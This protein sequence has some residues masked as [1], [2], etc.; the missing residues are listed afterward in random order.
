[1]KLV[2]IESP[3]A[4]DVET[5]VAYAKACVVD[6]LKRGESPY[7]SHLFFTQPGLLDDRL[8][9]ERTAGIH[10]GFAWGAKADLVAVYVD[11]G[12]SGGMKQGVERA[13]AAGQRIEYR[14]LD[15]NLVAAFGAASSEP[16]R[17]APM[18]GPAR[19][20]YRQCPDCKA[21][22]DCDERSGQPPEALQ[23][24]EKEGT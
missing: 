24:R 5:N 20:Q 18:P 19:K 15:G 16:E 21:Y 13:I 3:Y 17:S 11:R 1:M 8:P 2:V 9:I 4:G 12:M 22:C 23:R 7:A 10:A 14:S 6:S